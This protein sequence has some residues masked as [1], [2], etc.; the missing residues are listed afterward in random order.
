MFQK[1]SQ[2]HP[3]SIA[4]YLTVPQIA[5]A[6]DLTKHWIYDRIHNGYIHA[7]KDAQ[8]GLYLFP[9]KPSTLKMFKQLV[10]GQLYDLRFSRSIKMRGRNRL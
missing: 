10:D 7:T 4:G 9:D 8:T 1:R 3:R 2:S 5:Q 6:L